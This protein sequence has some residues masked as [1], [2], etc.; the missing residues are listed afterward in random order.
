MYLQC[1]AAHVANL[2]SAKPPPKQ[3]PQSSQKKAKKSQKAEKTAKTPKPRKTPTKLD[4]RR[5]LKGN[6]KRA[7]KFKA[8]HPHVPNIPDEISKEQMREMKLQHGIL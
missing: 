2:F 4:T 5:I 6:R 3:Q 7:K 1:T 8:M